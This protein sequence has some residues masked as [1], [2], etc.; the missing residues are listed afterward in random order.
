MSNSI[1][2]PSITHPWHRLLIDVIDYSST[3]ILLTKDTFLAF[4]YHLFPFVILLFVLAAFFFVSEVD[5]V[6]M[7]SANHKCRRYS[8][9]LYFT[10]PNQSENETNKYAVKN[11]LRGYR[12]FFVGKR[13]TASA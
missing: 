4:L 10:L 2:G 12:L 1:C 8:V 7:Q 13:N 9:V 3:I 5:H 6:E 11:R